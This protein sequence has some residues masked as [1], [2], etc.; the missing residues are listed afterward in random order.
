MELQI[1]DFFTSWSN[2]VLDALF[3]FTNFLGETG[4]FFF[5]FMIMYWVVSKDRAFRFASIYII[6]AGINTAFKN[7]F[8]RPRPHDLKGYGYSFPSGHAQGYAV[9]ATLIYNEC[10][11]NDFPK[12]KKWKT[13][14][15]LELII[16]GVL[17]CIGRM[18]FGMHYLSDVLMGIVLGICVACVM[19]IIYNQISQKF[20]VNTSKI[21]AFMLIPLLAMYF[22]V[23]FTS[24]INHRSAYTIY[25]V[26][27]FMFGSILGYF[28]D[29]YLLKTQIEGNF[30]NRCKKIFLGT[31]MM[32]FAYFFIVTKINNIYFIPLAFM[33]LG[34]ASTGIMPFVLNKT[35]V[36]KGE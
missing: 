26:T 17:V 28:V 24:L 29:K 32:G 30:A 11:I 15:I 19:D 25:S 16:A 14:I 8:A 4:F 2:S 27:G 5:V 20:K 36:V 10:K 1:V 35:F 18:Y 33:F 3:S 12:E 13:E 31:L 22:V 7:I 23:T 34:F 6:S 9:N 21:L